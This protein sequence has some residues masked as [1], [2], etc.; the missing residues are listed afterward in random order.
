[1]SVFRDATRVAI[2]A[3]K[4]FDVSRA[5]W[6][7]DGLGVELAADPVEVAEDP[8]E[9][10]F[11]PVEVAEDPVEFAFEPVEFALDPVEFVLDPVADTTEF[12]RLGFCEFG[13]EEPRD[14]VCIEILEGFTVVI[15]S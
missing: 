4:S 9:F 10:A 5:A 7:G 1:M 15:V 14:S 12:R 6:R 13:G 11:E 3:L 2:F 8:A